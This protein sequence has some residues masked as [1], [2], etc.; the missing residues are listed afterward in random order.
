MKRNMLADL[1]GQKSM[2]VGR[3]DAFWPLPETYIGLEIE[4]EGKYKTH[5]DVLRRWSMVEDHSL[6]GGIEFVF[7]KPPYLDAYPHEHAR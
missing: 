6:R 1:M 5:E 3:S 7:N 4:V 2:G